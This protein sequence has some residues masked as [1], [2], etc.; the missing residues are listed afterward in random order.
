[1][2]SK[3]QTIIE[4]L[5]LHVLLLTILCIKLGVLLLHGIT[6]LLHHSAQ[7]V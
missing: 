2:L 4:N 6:K 7:E 5:A 3:E 1:M